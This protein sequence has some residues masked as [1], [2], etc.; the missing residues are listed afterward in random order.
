MEGWEAG[1]ESTPE[2]SKPEAD[3]VKAGATP[4]GH[5]SSCARC[6]RRQGRVLTRAF[7]P[8]FDYCY[9]RPTSWSKV[10]HHM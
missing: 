9:R 3:L 1:L 8:C 10:S 6:W 7:A 4:P 2:A 5:P